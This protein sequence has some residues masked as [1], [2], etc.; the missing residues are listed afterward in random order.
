MT[1]RSYNPIFD[2][3]SRKVSGLKLKK[4]R[5]FKIDQHGELPSHVLK[6]VTDIQGK[7]ATKDAVYVLDSE[8]AFCVIDLGL[9]HGNLNK[10]SKS[11]WLSPRNNDG[12]WNVN[13]TW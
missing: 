10:H 7:P 12:S 9:A 3:D 5:A 11:A 6:I 13:I 4:M 1:I 8:I 2:P